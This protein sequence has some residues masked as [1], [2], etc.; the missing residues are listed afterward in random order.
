MGSFV[1]AKVSVGMPMGKVLVYG[2]LGVSSSSVHTPYDDYSVS[3]TNIGVGMDYRVTEKFSVGAEV[4]ARNFDGY[5]NG[6]DSGA[7]TSV[8]L[9]ASFHF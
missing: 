3:G 7:S 6:G 2:F 8:S 1:D 4:M 5:T 9:R